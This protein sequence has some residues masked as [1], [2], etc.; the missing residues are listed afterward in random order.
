MPRADDVTDPDLRRMNLGYVR[1]VLYGHANNPL[2][3]RHSTPRPRP[4]WGKSISAAALAA[5]GACRRVAPRLRLRRSRSN[6]T[7]GLD[8]TRPS[9]EV[10]APP[11]S[12]VV[13]APRG[14][15]QPPSGK[16][17]WRAVTRHLTGC[18][19]G[20]RHRNRCWW[21][22]VKREPFRCQQWSTA[23][24]ADDTHGQCDSSVRPMPAGQTM[25]I[26]KEPPMEY[27]PLTMTRQP[28]VPTPGPRATGVPS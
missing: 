27:A 13:L 14:D 24:G 4:T 12:V 22:S 20:V 17:R 19:P 6:G 7:A 2:C 11:R 25:S 8:S 3:R 18:R 21:R 1:T 9:I 10:A 23:I 26:V 15:P 5:T 28:D 16:Q